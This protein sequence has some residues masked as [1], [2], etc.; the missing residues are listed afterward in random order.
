MVAE[1]LAIIVL[2]TVLGAEAWHARRIRRVAML[3]FGPVG[4]PRRWTLAAPML[5]A[6]AAAALAWGLSTLMWLPPKVHHSA[7]VDKSKLRHLII[8]LDVSPS[9]RLQDAGPT[10]KQSRRA[11]A[12]DLIDSF[13]ARSG[14][15]FKVSVIAFYTGAKP[16]VVSMARRDSA[17]SPATKLCSSAGRPSSD[18]RSRW[19]AVCDC[20]DTRPSADIAWISD[21]VSRWPGCGQWPGS[22]GSAT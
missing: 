10:K 13:L 4:Q 22:V 3:A 14:A 8:L 20:I 9:M 21:H 11:R 15:D 2:L 1:M 5:R 7:V 19:D 18:A 17:T 12:R 16:V 6:I